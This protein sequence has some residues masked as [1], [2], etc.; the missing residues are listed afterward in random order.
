MSTEDDA[1]LDIKANGLRNSPSN[2]TRFVKIFN[3]FAKTCP[4]NIDDA[5]YFHENAKKLE[6]ESRITEVENASFNPL[7]FA[8]T[9]GAGPS[10]SR[11]MSRIA[12]KIS[13]KRLICKRD[14]FHKDD[15]LS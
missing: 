1:R 3:P 7:V 12:S 5:Y 10:A 2:K 13:E 15:S 9:G 14:N 11:V 6:Y 4:K 8:R